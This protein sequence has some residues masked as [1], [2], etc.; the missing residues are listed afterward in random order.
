MNL[1]HLNAKTLV[2]AVKGLSLRVL[3]VTSAKSSCQRTNLD[4][5]PRFRATIVQK[6]GSL[7]VLMGEQGSEC[8]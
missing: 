1:Y 4:G 6:G 3:G 8:R 5:D 7:L 2:S